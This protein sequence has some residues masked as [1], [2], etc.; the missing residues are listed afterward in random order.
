MR[1]ADFGPTPGSRPSS[2]IR[3]WTGPA[4]TPLLRRSGP[5]GA[6]TAEQAAEA[7]THTEAAHGLLVDVVDLGEGVVQGSQDEVFEHADVVGIDGAGVDADPLEIHA[8]VDRDLDH[9]APGRAFHDLL[10]RRGLS[11]HQ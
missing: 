4:Y 9:A 3:S 11:L 1:W 8:A 2:S 6:S 7:A 5:V 10:G